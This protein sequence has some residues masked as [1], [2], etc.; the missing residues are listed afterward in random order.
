LRPP[1]PD[2]LPQIKGRLARPQQK[3]TNLHIEYFVIK[4]TIEMGLLLRM[5][6]ASKFMHQYIMPLAKFYDVSVNYKK[7]LKENK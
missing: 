2:K 4:D 1:Q 6:I 3:S 5:E 7:Y